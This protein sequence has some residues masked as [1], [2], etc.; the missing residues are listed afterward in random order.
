MIFAHLFARNSVYNLH[1][2]A[3]KYTGK[4]KLGVSTIPTLRA[5]Q[6][7]KTIKGDA[8]VAYSFRLFFAYQVEGILHFIFHPINTKMTGSGK[9]EWFKPAI[10][11]LFSVPVIAYLVYRFG[12]ISK[13]A[14][15]ELQSEALLPLVAASIGGAL[16]LNLIT[17]TVFDIVVWVMLSA[18]R[19]MQ[20]AAITAGIYFTYKLI[21]SKIS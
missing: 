5:N 10:P 14:I 15:L 21:I 9:T 7:S 8:V 16:L 20:E 19:I 6:V 17:T 11:L 18:V 2:T 1:P 13:P 4:R 12:N 3:T